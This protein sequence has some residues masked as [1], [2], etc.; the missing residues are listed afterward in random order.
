MKNVLIA[1][2]G[3]SSTY[4]IDYMLKN[5]KNNWTV[6]VMDSNPEAVM[7]K[8][9]GHPK[10]EAAIIDIMNQNKRQELVAEADIVLSL[11]PPD[12]HILLAKDCL[13]FGKNIITSSYITKE[14]MALDE[15]VKAKGLLFMCEMGLDPG[16][17]HMSSAH[18]ISGIKRIG[19]E[20]HSF[21]S[22]CGGLVAPESDNNP[23]HYKVSWNP[24]NVVNAGKPNGGNW[25]EN[26]VVYNKPY[27]DLFD[28]C[29]RVK[30]PNE[31]IN[32]LSC[33]PNRTSVDYIKLYD[34]PEIK[35]FLRA[36]LRYTVFIKAWSYIVKAGLTDDADTFEIN[37]N[38]YKDW[39]SKKTGLANTAQLKE[40]F[41]AK[42]EVDD[43]SIK[44]L[45][46][47]GLFDAKQIYINK[48]YS[49]AALLQTLIEEKWK[50]NPLDKDMVVM[51]HDLEYK[52]K[53]Q[54]H[55]LTS[56]LIVKG[57]NR[58]YSAMAKTVGLPMA[59]LA[60]RMLLH[61]GIIKTKGVTIPTHA[62]IYVPV[63]KELEKNG[64]I[65]EEHYS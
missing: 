62:D 42:Y 10:G 20:I 44:L 1:G 34:L 24:K 58:N 8:L 19:G 9:A 26:N 51:M 52:R 39:V 56:T 57:E 29:K 45:E 53:G 36:T 15:E 59:I 38:F 63:L 21:K 35:T 27:K 12:L 49:S 65:F 64:I 40:L 46:W 2:A 13:K 48:T 32:S 18:I 3:K 60:K 30:I 22:F 14:M 55:K 4:L 33:Y 50:M 7:E 31:E 11:M 43:K 41:T 54:S 61:E 16:I 17:D 6:K 47:L 5:A 25:M 23:W 28:N 37:N